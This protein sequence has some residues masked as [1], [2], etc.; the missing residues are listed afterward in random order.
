MRG[1]LPPEDQFEAFRREKQKRKYRGESGEG[2]LPATS[3]SA[4]VLAE[5][6]RKEA[7]E[8]RLQREMQEFVEG[9]T[10]IAARILNQVGEKQAKIVQERI[11]REMKEF[12]RTTLQ[13]AEEMVRT[14]REEYGMRTEAAEIEAH[15]KELAADELD[16]FR[17]EGNQ[18]AAQRHLGQEPGEA[19]EKW[20]GV[21][22]TP[23]LEEGASTETE[24]P[25]EA[26]PLES[27]IKATASDDH[28]PVET[29]GTVFESDPPHRIE[30]DEENGSGLIDPVDL[31]I[32]SPEEDPG[33]NEERAG[34]G[35]SAEDA[36]PSTLAPWMTAL[37]KDPEKLKK[38]LTL[39]V[40]E[41]LLS[42]E[43]AREAYASVRK[44]D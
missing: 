21:T 2:G 5:D 24:A 23:L 19:R 25:G 10:R 43:Q 6:D 36:A 30:E 20:E 26:L 33:E 34:G 11:A 44:G 32:E 16:G 13:R 37:Q 38:A 22:R 31:A 40:A 9:T 35:T 8:I 12:F 39:M 41:G 4:R 28:G 27:R 17:F 3:D 14:L 7:L 15:L 42:R 29:L 1:Q 18:D